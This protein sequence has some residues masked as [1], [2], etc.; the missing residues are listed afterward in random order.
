MITLLDYSFGKKYT[1]KHSFDELPNVTSKMKKKYLY[2][3][4]DK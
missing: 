2:L 3:L 4:I 1:K